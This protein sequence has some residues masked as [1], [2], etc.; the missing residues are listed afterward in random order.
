MYTEENSP[1]RY[2]LNKL[3]F[4]TPASPTIVTLSGPTFLPFILYSRVDP[5]AHGRQL[6]TTSVPLATITA[7]AAVGQ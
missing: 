7:R 4:P 1:E 6:T 3:L 5:L 2:F